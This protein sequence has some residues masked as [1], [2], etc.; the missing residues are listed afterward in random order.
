MASRNARQDPKLN[1][2]IAAIR[3]NNAR[4]E[5]RHK[6]LSLLLLIHRK[7]N[8]IKNALLKLVALSSPLKYGLQSPGKTPSRIAV[9][10]MIVDITGGSK[11]KITDPGA[12]VAVVAPAS[13]TT[14]QK[15]C[16]IAVVLG[17]ASIRIL[18]ITPNHNSSITVQKAVEDTQEVAETT[19]WNTFVMLKLTALGEEGNLKSTIS[20]KVAGIIMVRSIFL[21]NF[22]NLVLHL[23]NGSL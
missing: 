1:E 3:E 10:H 23:F 18:I 20:T 12:V 13:D 2:R 17:R 14:Y 5:S 4:L 8:W 15:A 11:G 19:T 21:N 7:L 6:V 16:K 22:S 9:A